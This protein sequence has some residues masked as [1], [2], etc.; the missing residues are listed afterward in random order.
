MWPSRFDQ[1]GRLDPGVGTGGVLRLD[2]STGAAEG[3]AY[4]GDTPW[5][6]TRLADDKLL[7]VAQVA[8]GRSDLAS[9]SVNVSGSLLLG[10]P[11]PPSGEKTSGGTTVPGSAL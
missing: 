3:N 8:P 11:E 1:D 10:S 6:L 7:V 4:R 5:G 2:L 9:L